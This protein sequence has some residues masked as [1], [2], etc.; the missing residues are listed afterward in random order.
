MYIYIVDHY[1]H[2]GPRE[3]SIFFTHFRN[4]KGDQPK[5]YVWAPLYVCIYIYI[6]R[7]REREIMYTHVYIRT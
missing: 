7:E 4:K 3:D 1:T 5:L 6:Y 2:A